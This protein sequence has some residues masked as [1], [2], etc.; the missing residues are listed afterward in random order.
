MEDH[1][2]QT[3]TQ[4]QNLLNSGNM[5]GVGN[6]DIANSIITNTLLTSMKTNNPLIDAIT[7][8]VLISKF[9]SQ[10]FK[11]ISI[12]SVLVLGIIFHRITKSVD[13]L[14][15][16]YET[17]LSYYNPYV[18]IQYIPSKYLKNVLLKYNGN[19]LSIRIDNKQSFFEIKQQYNLL[20]MFY[21]VIEKYP[22]IQ[23]E[24]ADPNEILGY[25]AVPQNANIYRRLRSNEDYLS[26]TDFENKEQTKNLSIRVILENLVKY[27]PKTGKWYKLENDIDFS[28]TSVKAASPP[29]AKDP[30]PGNNTN[31]NSRSLMDFSYVTTNNQFHYILTLKSYIKTTEELQKYL[32]GSRKELLDKLVKHEID[33]NV[34]EQEKLDS[35]SNKDFRGDIYEISEEELQSSSGNNTASGNSNT[36]TIVNRPKQYRRT[37]V[38]TFCRPL[39]S[40]FFKEKDQLMNIL[41]NFK[42][43]KGIYEKLPHRHKIGVLIYGKP[44]GGKCFSFNTNVMMFSGK[45]KMIQDIKIGDRIMGDD[46]TPRTIL[47]T[48]KGKESMYKIKQIKG[49]EYVVNE[50]HILS[51]KLSCTQKS[52]TTGK[53]NEFRIINGHKYRKGDTVDISVKDYLTLASSTKAKLKGYKVPI[54]FPEQKLPIDPYIIGLWLG[55]GDSAGSGFTNQDAT[56]LKYLANNLPNYNCYLQ[57]QKTLYKYSINGNGRGE[58]FIIRQLKQLNLINNKH[59]PDIYKYNSRENQLK[60][61]A[62]LLDTDGH[63]RTDHVDYDFVQKNY[64]LAKDVEFITRCLGFSS[65]VK[66][67]KKGCVYKG[68]YK[69]GTYYRQCIS[70]N[71]IDEIPCLVPRKK[72]AIR[73]QVKNN[74]YTGITV[75]PVDEDYYT[76][77]PEYEYYY[78]FEI[79][80]NHRFVLGDHTVTHNTSLSVAIATELKR[81]I[82]KI[83]LK[84][85]DLDDSKL[86]HILNSYKKGYVIILD[87]LDTHKSFRPRVSEEEVSNDSNEYEDRFGEI[88][89][90]YFGDDSCTITDDSDCEAKERLVKEGPVKEKP[91]DLGQMI[92]KFRKHKLNK[93]WKPP[94]KLTL[95]SFLEAMDGISSTEERV[96]IAM[97]NHPKMLD[98]A[99]IRPGRFDIVINMDSLDQPYM[100]LYFKYLF[101]DFK[102]IDTQEIENA[103]VFATNNKI[104]TSCL[105][106]ACIEKFSVKETK[107]LTTCIK[108]VYESFIF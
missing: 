78:G 30:S 44:G 68:E 100:H 62:G 86:S 13:I 79:D 11:N 70:G 60:L 104:S 106:Q 12:V 85:K 82:V 42:Q 27:P 24:T 15:T 40:I 74:L 71:G 65:V 1:Q 49:D 103:C 10:F 28:W 38:N 21:K 108:D 96:V 92:R 81:N 54:I 107:T 5:M 88:C 14:N 4:V 37:L 59:I 77:G 22:D 36:F 47:S 31:N 87:E 32:D 43:K 55:D 56:I 2:T 6:N 29:P 76:Q 25:S 16:I 50:S 94:E 34:R 64:T 35:L 93:G 19:V 102:H 23:C 7:S 57:S 39:E 20:T 9:K 33:E 80:G 45:F 53:T 84:D 98:P 69:E 26:Y 101:K 75:E 52:G 18:A 83:S 17:L 99:I 51:L 67:C 90:D 91:K 8:L 105:E 63:Y 97:T 3:Q 73:K 58:N 72:S 95:G 41:T 61:L 89:N 48:C 66:E 46:S